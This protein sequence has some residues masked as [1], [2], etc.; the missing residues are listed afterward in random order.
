MLL[1]LEEAH[2]RYTAAAHAI[3]LL[4]TL[5]LEQDV[6]EALEPILLAS[7]DV[8]LLLEYAGQ[9]QEVHEGGGAAVDILNDFTKIAAKTPLQEQVRM[10]MYLSEPIE[11]G[12]GIFVTRDD[13]PLIKEPEHDPVN[14]HKKRYQSSRSNR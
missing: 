9:L 6:T 4:Q 11:M 1:N 8:P 3:G 13:A 7:M 2:K 14:Q 10:D 12:D 5:P